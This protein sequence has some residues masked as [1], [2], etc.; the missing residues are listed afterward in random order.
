MG[1][2][3]IF[4]LLKTQNHTISHSLSPDSA[5]YE[6]SLQ[7]PYLSLK[8]LSLLPAIQRFPIIYSQ[9]L[10]QLILRLLHLGVHLLQ[11]LPLRQL[12]P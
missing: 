1:P 8:G 4:R 5:L 2:N 3:V 9:T 10:H 7:P 12:L 6:P 11:F